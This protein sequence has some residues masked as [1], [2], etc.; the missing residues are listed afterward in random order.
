MEYNKLATELA[1]KMDRVREALDDVCGVLARMRL[2]EIEVEKRLKLF[3]ARLDELDRVKH[4]H[5]WKR[6]AR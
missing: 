1:E 2:S 5:F 3:E 4:N 6:R